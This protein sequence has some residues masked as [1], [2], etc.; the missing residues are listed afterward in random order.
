MKVGR[1][2]VELLG[3]LATVLAVAGV[4]LNNQRAIACFP[5]WLGSN[6]VACY[7]HAR[8]RLWTLA[9]RDV[10]FFALALQGW[11]FWAQ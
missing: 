11:W 4:V 9:V 6:A 5:L 8:A 1:L 7:L 10:V 2:C 3:V